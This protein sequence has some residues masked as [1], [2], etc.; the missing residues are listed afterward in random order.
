MEFIQVSVYSLKNIRNARQCCTCCFN[1]ASCR[2]TLSVFNYMIYYHYITYI[3]KSSYQPWNSELASHQTGTLL[4]R[5]RYNPMYKAVKSCP[6]PHISSRSS[7]SLAQNI[8]QIFQWIRLAY[9]IYSPWQNFDLF[10]YVISFRKRSC[11]RTIYLRR[12]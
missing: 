12:I 6:L 11:Q 8:F 5:Q 1:L 2:Y 10:W 7:L 9:Y 3:I 4:Q